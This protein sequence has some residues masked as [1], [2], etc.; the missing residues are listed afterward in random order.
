[1]TTHETTGK[2]AVFLVEDNP[3]VREWLR[4]LISRQSDLEICGDAPSA[5]EAL[6]KIALR[7][8]DV[9]IVDISLDGT[10]GLN[11]IDQL[12]SSYPAVATIVLSM[13]EE[14][15]YA[16][17]ALRAGARGYVMKRDATGKI[18]EAIRQV[19]SGKPFLSE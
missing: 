12:R 5:S 8:P 11:F 14:S 3:L 6:E 16:E 18:V 2:A 4:N 15:V 17:R 10:S 9:V 13:H 1:M 19:L 7:Q